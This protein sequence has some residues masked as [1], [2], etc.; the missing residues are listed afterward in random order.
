MMSP[1]PEQTA[2]IHKLYLRARQKRHYN[3]ALS[4][5]NRI[6]EHYDSQYNRLFNRWAKESDKG[7]SSTLFGSITGLT[8][9]E[10]SLINDLFSLK[11]KLLQEENQ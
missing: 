1:N 5:G 3:T 9:L 10:E 2:R 8:K 7:K 6:R 11:T 4:L